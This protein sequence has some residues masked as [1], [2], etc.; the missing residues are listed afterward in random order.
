[1]NTRDICDGNNGLPEV[2]ILQNEPINEHINAYISKEE[3]LKCIQKLKN[4]KAC[5]E[6]EIINEYI[7]STSNQFINI[8]EK[9]FNIIFDKGFVPHIWLI[10]TIKPIYKNKGD[11]YEPKN[12]R[13]ITIVSCLGKLFTSILNTRLNNFSEEYRLIKENQFG[14]RQNYST[15]DNIFTLF[16]FFQIIKLKK[17]KL[18]CAFIDFEKAFDKVWRE[19][20]FY[21]M[22][23][24]KINGKMYNVIINMYDSIKSCISYNNCISEYFDC[25]NGVRQGENLSP[26]LFSLFLN[27]VDTFL[28]N[29]NITGLQAIS[30]EIENNLDIYLKLFILLYA[31]DTAL[32]AETANDLQTQLDAFY[33]YC[34]LWKL[35]VN[36]DKTK[37]MV[38]GN[39]R[40][41]QNLSFSYDNLNLEIVKNFNYLGIIFT[42]TG[43]F[44]LT[45]KHL[46]DKALKAM[47]EVL[48][49]GRM[50]KL[51]IKCLLDL[52]D[53]MIK[54]ILLYGCEVWGFSN[55][56]ILEKLH[57]KFCKILLNLK[58][59]TPSYM[60]YGELGR[61]PIYIDIKIRT[62]CYWARLIVGKQTK[63]SNILYRLCRQLN[64]NHNMQFSW[65]LFVKQIFNECGFPNIWETEL[66]DNVD[67]L[68]C[69]IKQRLEDRFLQNWNSLVQ[70]SPKAINYKTI[71]TEFKYEEY[72][73]ILEIKDAI[74]L[75][76]FST[77]NNKLPIETGRW[78]NIP[79][80]NRKC[81]YV[82][83]PKL[84]MNTIIFLNVF[85]LTK[86]V[87][88]HC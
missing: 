80:E 5:G 77:T 70:N 7:K 57:L 40:L 2:N 50:Y 1:M 88:S 87:S 73:N 49:M 28:E 20:L 51:S 17:R 45:K 60:V 72:L 75:C 16:S 29:K 35:K 39:G 47:Y 19:G 11:I 46:A 24:N 69:V 36:A 62:V 14:F 15:I 30:D 32:L 68:K 56:D 64:E 63:Y 26:F 18:F 86:N 44:S 76:R 67:Y 4:E 79:R 81:M 83:D 74:L 41:P 25:A 22:M 27:D 31:D 61:Y 43:N 33:E 65:I 6:D 78:Q 53:K 21:K 71:K 84:E 9:L 8:Y 23:L 13:P 82:I 3:I 34:N 85:I 38:F 10:G 52:F 66:F 37:V 54:P 12:Y 59:S 42:R 48:K 55:N 58:T